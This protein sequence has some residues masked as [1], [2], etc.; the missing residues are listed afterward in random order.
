MGMATHA[1]VMIGN[2]GE[3]LD[4]IDEMF[5]LCRRLSDARRDVDR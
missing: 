5:H 2:P 4:D 1:H 3:T